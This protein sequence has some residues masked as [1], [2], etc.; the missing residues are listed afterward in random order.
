[1]KRTFF[2]GLLP[3][4]LCLAQGGGVRDLRCD[5]QVN[6]R[7]ITDSHPQLSWTWAANNIPRGYQIL[8]ASSEE[9]LKAENGDLW[10]SG[11]VR[12]DR[13]SAQYEGKP[14]TS[15]QRCYWKVRVWSDYDTPTFYTEPATWQMGLLPFSQPR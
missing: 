6:P 11:L 2:L 12:T 1:M 13:K 4:L 15:Y 5:N 7:A 8:V 3:A 14:L 9:K 10:D